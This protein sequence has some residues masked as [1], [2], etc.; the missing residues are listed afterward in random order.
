[1]LIDDFL[2]NK[3]TGDDIIEK[4]YEHLAN[5][6]QY[7]NNKNNL[8]ERKYDIYTQI[9]DTLLTM[10]LSQ[11]NVTPLNITSEKIVDKKIYSFINSIVYKF[12]SEDNS[13]KIRKYLTWVK[14]NDELTKSVCYVILSEKRWALFKSLYGSH[15]KAE[16]KK[17]IDDYIRLYPY[18]E[19]EEG[20]ILYSLF[21]IS[22]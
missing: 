16:I 8:T 3:L 9:L 5:L 1:M 2:N 21:N 11:N 10:W 14:N 7:P 4:L 15:D 22:P 12:I 13:N 19:Y 17:I 20:W 18:K 6:D